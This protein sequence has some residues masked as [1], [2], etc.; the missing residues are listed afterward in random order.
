[1]FDL[2]FFLVQA[3]W[4]YTDGQTTTPF[5][6]RTAGL[7]EKAYQDKK[8]T[9]AWKGQR[10]GKHSVTFSTMSYQHSSGNQ[11]TVSRKQHGSRSRVAYLFVCVRHL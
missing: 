7:L 10:G 8:P 5:D 11:F 1:M 4:E 2:W 6:Q 9:C 3:D